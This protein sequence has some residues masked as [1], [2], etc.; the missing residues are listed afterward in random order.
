MMSPF[1][2]RHFELAGIVLCVLC[3]VYFYLLDHI[4]F[5]SARFSPIFRLLLTKYDVKAAWLALAVSVLAG[6]WSRPVPIQR[7]VH[8]MGRHPIGFAFA[9]MIGLSIGAIVTYHNYPLSMDEYAAV[10]QAKIFATGGLVAQV[11]PNLVDWLVVRGFN[12]AFLIASP[13]TGKIMEAYWP[14]FALLLT[15]F[16]FLNVPWLCNASLSGLAIFLIHWIT[17]EITG[18]QLAAGWA[19]L[20]TLASGVFAADGISYYSMQ[21]HMTANLLFV[22]LLIT[23]T[24]YRAFGAGLVGSLALILHNPL[25]HALFAIPWI[26]AMAAQR[27]RRRYLPALFC[28]YLPGAVIAFSWLALR[29][30]MTGLR[31]IASMPIPADVFS[32]PNAAIL[33]SRVAAL[34]K[35]STW[36]MPCLFAFAF[37]GFIRRRADLRVRLLVASVFFTFFAYLFVSFDQGH[38]WGY[39]YFHSAWAAIPILAG[40]SMNV[41]SE[42]N[43]RLTSFAGATAV[44]GVLIIVPFQMNQIDRVISEHLAQLEPPKRP[45]NNVYLV[46]PLGGFYVADMIQSDPMLRNEDLILVSHGSELDARLVQENWPNAIKVSSGRV[47]DQW[48]LGSEDRRLMLPDKHGG[49]QYV[50]THVP[51]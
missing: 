37:L 5:S 44:L 13:E 39:R 31:F 33:N 3:V 30:E 25:P 47:A 19:I 29:A 12:G 42:A 46:H 28:G 50:L 20:F 41:K 43:S 1:A 24:A 23:P 27:D 21:A 40:C 7:L 26:A 32:W 22:A 10:Y 51:P 38:G 15:P 49:S 36:A 2:R 11:P 6:L 9:S 48:Y 18:E 4:L 8:F 35:M 17:K 14:G 45:G 16:Q 34:V